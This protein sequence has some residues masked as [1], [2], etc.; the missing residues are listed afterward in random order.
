MMRIVSLV[1]SLTELVFWLGAGEQL[2]GRTRFCT[3][4]VGEAE[5]VPIVGGT[6]NPKVERIIGLAPD[7]VLAN[8]EENRKDDVDALRA[9]G[10][11]VLVTD[12]NTVAEAVVMIGELGVRFGCEQQAR[13]LVGE[14]AAQLAVPA[15]RGVRVFAAVWKEP[16]MGLGAASYGHDLL[17]VAGA[18]NVL[19]GRERYPVVT[20][21][22][23]EALKP[24]LILL[25][26]EPFPFAAEDERSWSGVASARVIDGKLLWWYGPRIPEALAAFRTMFA[27]VAVR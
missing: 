27:G 5:H 26:D 3:E 9:A 16:L 17:T 23:V 11:D 22:E 21:D 4:P 14:I 24:D 8:K 25:P 20:R 2:V 19:A 7:L 10:L 18:I 15:A 13:A 1:P 12:P 6:K